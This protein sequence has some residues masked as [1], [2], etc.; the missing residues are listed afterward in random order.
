MTP[1]EFSIYYIIASIIL[2]IL[3]FKLLNAIIL[4]NKIT[5]PKVLIDSIYYIIFSL[6]IIVLFAISEKYIT[7]AMQIV[8]I[9]IVLILP[10]ILVSWRIL[11]YK[12][13]HL[14]YN[15]YSWGLWYIAWLLYLISSFWIA[16]GIWFLIHMILWK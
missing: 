4:K 3:K 11:F 14:I 6:S 15:K 16:M 9:F 5:L 1:I 13:Y 10:V 12:K 2:F 8:Q 7:F